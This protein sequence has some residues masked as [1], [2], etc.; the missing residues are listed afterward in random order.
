[1][2]ESMFSAKKLTVPW[3]P[4]RAAWIWPLITA[5]LPA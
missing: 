5:L 4:V 3:N 1:M 2:G